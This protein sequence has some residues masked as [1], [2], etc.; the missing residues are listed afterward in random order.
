M[1]LRIDINKPHFHTTETPTPPSSARPLA[2]TDTLRSYTKANQHGLTSCCTTIFRSIWKCIT[3]F[4][5]FLCCLCKSNPESAKPKTVLKIELLSNEG[6]TDADLRAVFKDNARKLKQIFNTVEPGLG[7]FN[8][9]RGINGFYDKG[10]YVV[11][12]TGM[13]CGG[14]G[15]IEEFQRLPKREECFDMLVYQ[16]KERAKSQK[17]LEA[18]FDLKKYIA[19]GLSSRYTVS[20][21]DLITNAILW[22]EV[23]NW[24]PHLLNILTRD[25]PIL[26]GSITTTGGRKAF[27]ALCKYSQSYRKIT[28]EIQPWEKVM[29]P[30]LTDKDIW[31][32]PDLTDEDS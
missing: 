20:M 14:V 21:W 9:I 22:T 1:S 30:G 2:Q 18:F 16:L 11:N 15:T 13:Q 23:A 27:D 10:G 3:C 31:S 6:W 25:Y 12:E 17:E 7:V 28:N 19:D 32:D 29:W 26:F 24:E 8:C 4:F 5:D